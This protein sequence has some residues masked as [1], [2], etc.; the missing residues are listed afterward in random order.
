MT[1]RPILGFAAVL[2]LLVL[3]IA[4]SAR[5]Q[6][7][8]APRYYYPPAPRPYYA[9]PATP[10]AFAAPRTVYRSYNTYGN[11]GLYYDWTTGRN[12]LAIPIAKPWLRP[13]R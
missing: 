6:A 3:G 11:R 1:R 9:S 8:A 13:L 5:A 7:P 2:A 4:T 10:H 12:I